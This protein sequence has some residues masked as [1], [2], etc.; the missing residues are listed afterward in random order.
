[1]R[2]VYKMKLA[3]IGG[4]S[5]TTV[6][7]ILGGST[8]TV[9]TSIFPSIENF[10]DMSVQRNMAIDR[11]FLMQEAYD[12]CPGDKHAALTN[13][14]GFLIN[15]YPD[16]SLLCLGSKEPV[17]QEFANV[18]LSPEYVTIS[19]VK[20]SARFIC[21]CAIQSVDKLL[22]T[23]ASLVR[24]SGTPAVAVEQPVSKPAAQ[25]NTTAPAQP[26]QKQDKKRPSIFSKLKNTST[27]Q[28]RLLLLLKLMKKKKT[29]SL[30]QVQRLLT[31]HLQQARQ[32]LTLI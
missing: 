23:Y 7:G 10:M 18:F 27:K 22:V 2:G 13:L 24:S 19:V 16:V 26:A 21:D 30:Q 15:N 11:V 12:N 17:L 8:D 5:A 32:P 31:L 25:T 6:K 9:E 3:I 1:M 28:L 20:A 14:Y 29:S 4:S